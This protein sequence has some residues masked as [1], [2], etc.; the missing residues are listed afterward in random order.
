MDDGLLRKLDFNSIKLLKILGEE[1][2][3]KRTAER[4]FL[5][6]PAVSKQLKKLREDIGDE[7]FIRR[8]YGLEPTPYCLELLDKL[9]A[10]FELL[11]DVFSRNQNFKPSE[12]TGDICI[13]IN[14]SMY[15]PI[16]RKL[17]THLSASMPN[18]T[19]KIINWGQDTE[20]NLA[21]ARVHIGINYLP[22]D[23]SKQIIQKKVARCTFKLVCREGHPIINTLRTAHDVGQYP[24]ALL[25][26]PDF[27]KKENLIETKLRES[28]V[29]PN[30][31]LRADQLSICLHV[32]SQSNALM[33][34]IDI[35]DTELPKGTRFISP[36]KED[37]PSSDIGAFIPSKLSRTP[38]VTWLHKEIDQIFSHAN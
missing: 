30:V 16:S 4:M 11:E 9:P 5:S 3:T 8:Q 27:N 2:N 35:F 1:R 17:Y 12:Y 7:L 36:N 31:A 32:V 20:H 10:L 24:L 26:L 6:Q 37:T 34:C 19:L 25:Q 18:A 13:A 22:L 29:T 38:L 28:G 14:T 33:P 21:M 15:R 23:I